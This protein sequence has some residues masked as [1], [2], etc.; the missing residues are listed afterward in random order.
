LAKS[1]AC[2]IVAGEAGAA[3][4]EKLLL[5]FHPGDEPQALV[6]PPGEW[7]P[8]LHSAAGSLTSDQPVV[9]QCRLSARTVLVLRQPLTPELPTP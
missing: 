3:P 8:V 1:L 9:A 2:V 4:T 5:A 6:L 7:L